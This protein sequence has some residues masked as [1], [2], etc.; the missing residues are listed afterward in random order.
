[1]QDIRSF[2]TE[3]KN[4][5]QSHNLGMPGAYKRWLTQSENSSRNLGLNVYACANAANILYSIGE[6]PNDESDRLA[7]INTLQSFQDKSTGLFQGDGH[8]P[9]HTTAFVLGALELFDAK[10][11][12]PIY[13]LE[14]YAEKEEL[15]NLLDN[16]DWVNNPWAQSHQGAGIYAAMVLS[17]TASLQWQDWYFEWLRDNADPETGLWRKD[18]IYNENG[19][20]KGAPIFHHLASS[21]HY[22]FN[23]EYAKRALPYAEKIVDTCINMYKENKCDSFGEKISFN[24]VDF[25]YTLSRC[26]RR[27]GKRFEEFQSIIKEIADSFIN[28]IMS[29]DPKT[30]PG[31]N[32]LHSLSAVILALAVIQDCLPGY[33]K[34][35]KPLKLVLDRRPFI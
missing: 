31:L 27:S 9:I 32:D 19:K 34:T 14:R 3:V 25:V 33:I 8:H 12:Y 18:A 1:M 16:L 17:G 20:E 22:V 15:K 10:T 11:K 26:Q 23:H 4:I 2:I 13:D 6:F 35:E 28:Y 24:E 29:L 21:F 7:W 5:I 30:H